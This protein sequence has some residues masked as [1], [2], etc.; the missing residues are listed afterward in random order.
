ML[1]NRILPLTQENG[2]SITV[3]PWG[4]FVVV[5]LWKKNLSPLAVSI[6]TTE[7]ARELTNMLSASESAAREN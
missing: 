5:T 4:V 2:K 3:K 7:E 1:F 6:L